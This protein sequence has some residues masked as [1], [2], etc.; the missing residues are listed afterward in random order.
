MTE[1]G[2]PAWPA[3]QSLLSLV[4]VSTI[5]MGS[6]GP[7]T[8]SVTAL[9][10]AFGFRR[11]LFYLIGVILGTI[12]VLL[13][14]ATGTFAILLSVRPVE[15]VLVAASTLYLLYL[16]FR[17]AAAP[18]LSR[19]HDSGAAPSFTGGLVL[20]I[21]NPKAYV[22]IAAVFSGSTVITGSPALDSAI[23]TLVLAGMIVT[24][25]LCWLLA[26]ASL[27]RFLHDPF[28]SRIANVTFAA[29]LVASVVIPL[30]R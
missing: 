15:L 24:I 5:V 30:L 8:M 22:A 2:F 11:T 21:A 18:P 12:I 4:V 3:W 25:H 29:A 17:I 14:V 28:C 1:P 23:K 26:G 7:T 10:A 16:A 9:G 19:L 6:P 13:A 20:A 27:S